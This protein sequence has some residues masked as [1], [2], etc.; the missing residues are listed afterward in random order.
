MA[1]NF[2]SAISQYEFADLQEIPIKI[3]QILYR[4]K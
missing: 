3:T 1:A 2:I 4:L